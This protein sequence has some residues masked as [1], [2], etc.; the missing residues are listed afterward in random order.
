[1][2]VFAQHNVIKDAPFTRVDLIAC[3]NL[4]IYLQPA[5]QQKVLSLFH[6]SLNRGG[7]LFLGPSESA[8][9][10]ARSF[11]GVDKHWRIY[12]KHSD[13]RVPVEQRIQPIARSEVRAGSAALPSP[14]G[15]FSLSALLASYE[16]LLTDVLPPSLLVSERGELI[17]AFGGASRFL[18]LRDGRVGLDV[19]DLVDADLKVV[20]VGTLKRVLHEPSPIVY[21]AVRL[22]EGEHAGVYRVS[23]RRVA[24]AGAAPLVLL[25]F[26]PSEAASAERA[27]PDE[28]IEIDQGS[29]AQLRVLELELSHTKENLQSAIEELEASNEELQASNEELQASNEEL[30]S[31]NEELQSVNEELYTVNAEYQRKIGELIELTN[32]MDNLLSSTDIGTIFLDSRL[33]IRKFTPRI[34]ETFDL[35]PHDVG[36]SIET[37]A[38]KLD[39]A[40]L[41]DDMRR[42]LQTGLPVERELP[43]VL[44]K[45]FFL[46]VLPYRVK[47]AADGVVVTLID[48]SGLKAAEDALFHERHLLDGLLLNV[49]DAIYFKDARG[50]FIRANQAMAERLGLSDPADAAGKTALELPNQEAAL[51]LHKEDEAV[52][53]TGRPQ[54]YKLEA[55]L[56]RGG[57]ERWDLVSRLPLHDREGNIVGVIVVFR[58]VTEQKQA[59]EKIHEA[60][61]RRDQ[62]LAML[63]HEL[64]NPLGAIVTATALLKRDG[65]APRNRDRFLDV[66]ERQSQ[67]MS[68][69][70]DDLLEASRVTQNKIELKKRVIDLVSVTRDAAEAVRGQMD[71]SSIELALELPAEPLHVDGDPARLQ[72]IHVN[73]LNNAAKYT[74]S[75]GHVRLSVGREGGE[76]VV[77]VRDD[78]AGIPAHMLDSVFELFVQSSRTLDRSAGGLGLGLTLVRSLVG[79]HGGSVAAHSDGE[80]KGSEFVVRLPLSTAVAEAEPPR[81][82]L[83]PLRDTIKVVIV[84]DN[85]DTREMLCELLQESGF[86]C[87]SAESG[88]AAL[89]LI[90]E[91]RP[92]IALLDL[93]LPEMDGLEVARRLR[94]SP[95]LSGICLVALTGYGQPADRA[96]ALQAGFD[97]HLVKPVHADDLLKLLARLRGTSA[98]STSSGAVL[99]PK[100][101][102]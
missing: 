95:E 86:Q 44:G 63:S 57:G 14:A 68:R 4:L 100:Q 64:R 84:E 35:V 74:S 13:A 67:Q 46:R 79:M 19:L 55:C 21:R 50:R 24:R 56:T 72:Q 22:G 3:R 58:D 87:S 42:V 9:P 73:L 78:G 18:R 15:R 7:V 97:E 11:E 48:V 51:E 20:L 52:L 23:A 54:H 38:S 65:T 33:C 62:F 10:L 75:G 31:T 76:A 26:E 91:V 71:E 45:S 99:D 12:R 60:V 53:R 77:R 1:M 61:R 17:H 88:A 2:L 8:G 94:Q 69:L 80:G 40:E 34:A 37:F 6:F 39:H 28:A 70:L 36:R 66:L 49:P 25:S 16:S 27:A 5:V 89:A 43:G 96:M 102:N 30:Q 92:D 98:P 32:D 101:Q 47:G 93:G 90:D 59:E 81:R 29:R 82:A 83:R 85:A 41:V